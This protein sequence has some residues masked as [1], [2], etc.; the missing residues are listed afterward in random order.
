MINMRLYITEACNARCPNCF[1]WKNRTKTE[2]KIKPYE[3]ICKMLSSAGCHQIKIMGGE[4]TIHSNFTEF[5][6]LAQQYFP[7]VSVFTNAITNEITKFIPRETD[8][9]TYNFKFHALLD[10]QRLLLNHAGKRN[11]EIQIT[12]NSIKEKLLESIIKVCS[13]DRQRITPCLTLDCTSDI[14]QDKHK[15]VENYEFILSGCK[16]EGIKV[17]QDHLIPICFLRDTHIPAPD[18][19]AICKIDCAGLIDANYNLRFCNQYSDIL[20]SVFTKNGE[21]V[22]YEFIH[23]MLLKKHEQIIHDI[24]TK[25]CGDCSLFDVLCNGG[26]FANKEKCKTEAIL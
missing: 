15:I 20:G 9:I 11:L 4:P 24:L 5:M 21:I 8:I 13:L 26:C 1:N 6:V 17:G 2:M 7:A 16:E 22:K 25:G 3:E 18:G 10:E 23:Q 12:H 19:K 14:F